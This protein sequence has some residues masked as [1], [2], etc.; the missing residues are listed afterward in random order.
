MINSLFRHL[1]LLL[2]LRHD[3]RGLPAEP[4]LR[5]LNVACLG[6]ATLAVAIRWFGYGPAVLDADKAFGVVFAYVLPAVLSLTFRGWAVGV[7]YLL[8]VGAVEWM[9]V[10]ATWLQVPFWLYSMLLCWTPIATGSLFWGW[11]K[12]RKVSR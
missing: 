9:V 1:F 5:G 10:L 8:I 3:G 12:N 4:G 11:N 2:T 6:W 7:G